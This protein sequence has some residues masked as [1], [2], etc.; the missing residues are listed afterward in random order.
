M[1]VLLQLI[2]IGVD[3]QAAAVPAR[4]RFH[5]VLAVPSGEP[6]SHPQHDSSF[7]LYTYQTSKKA[8]PGSEPPDSARKIAGTSNFSAAAA[9]AFLGKGAGSQLASNA[10]PPVIVSPT[11]LL[12]PPPAP[13]LAP[14]PPTKLAEVDLLDFN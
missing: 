11:Q 8:L 5:A 13:T 14:V 9:Q 3:G 7:T 10:S 4:D 2:G 12:N 6:L 1:H